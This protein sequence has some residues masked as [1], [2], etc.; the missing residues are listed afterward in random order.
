VPA[1]INGIG[2]HY[3]GAQNRS[4]RVDTCKFCRRSATLSSYD[5]R[6]WFCVIF[7]PLIPM[8]KFRILN[9]CA[10]CRKH[11]RI[12]ADEFA[13]KLAQATAP[14]RQ[15][16][17]TSPRDPQP[18]IELV[19]TLIGW[20]MRSDADRELQSA[21]GVFPQ[22]LGL[23]VLAAQLAVD[24]N[25]FQRAVS[26]Y[27]RACGLDPQNSAA[28]Y[29]YGWVLQH[30]ERYEQAVPLL[31]RSISQDANKRGALYLL[32]KCQM[33][34]S[35]WNDALN[36]FQQLLSVEPAFTKDKQ[37]LRLMRDCK[38]QLGYELTDAE[39]RAGRRLW[40]FGGGTRKR[41]SYE[42]RPNTLVR[43]SLRYAGL[44]ILAIMLLG[45]GFY[46]WD[47]WTNIEVYFD[48]GLDRSVKV[49]LD[50]QKFDV[51]LNSMHTENVSAGA[52]TAIIRGS[53]G[54]EIERLA[55]SVEKLNPFAALMHDRFFVY[56]I[57]TR[58]V[59]RRA[60][61]GYA[62]HAED[63]TYK[64][65]LIGTQRFFEQRDVDFPFMTPP[66]TI[67]LDSTQ[68]IAT[69]VS[70]NIAKEID[71]RKY[72][73]IRMQQGK[74][75]EAK[76][77]IERAVTIAPCDTATRRTEIYL[78]SATGSFETASLTARRW[79]ADCAQDDLEAHRAYQDVNRENGRQE[80][81]RD[82][83]QKLLASSPASGKAHYLFGRVMADPQEAVAQ[84]QEAV[85][86]D[87]KLVWPR[88][89][90]GHAY[91]AMER[92]DAALQEFAAALDMEGCDPSVIVY[93]AN[94]AISKGKP[95]EAVAKVEENRKAHARDLSVLHARWLLA[96]ASADWEGA[97]RM[98]KALKPLETPQTGWWRTAK[99]M[100]MK[101]DP[102][103]DSII[104]K[105]MRTRDFQQIAVDLKIERLIQN[106][107][108]HQSSDLIIK[109]AKE[110]DPTGLAMLEA[111]T[112][113]GLL[114][115]HENNAAQ[116][117]LADAEK[118][119][120]DA[121]TSSARQVMS[122]VVKGLRGTMPLDAVMG[123]ARE[124]D[125]MAHGWF[126]D[127]VL[128]TQAGDRKRASESFGH[129]VRAAADLDFPYLE[130]RAMSQIA[131]R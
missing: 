116:K 44:V 117:L 72:A 122:A 79:I 19:Q 57:G 1:T 109:S 64:S 88:V 22:N 119:L 68:S 42:P 81:L 49:V 76:A 60:S 92:F 73:L 56:N 37:L 13:Q 3:Y 9:D 115:Q 33:K 130:A 111:Y 39:R 7:I 128:A 35:R 63:A 34:L 15:A 67:S 48:N 31:Q 90:L 77:A 18:Y 10:S 100:R 25:D 17:R 99:Q 23:M 12:P 89:A 69:K 74:Q 129:C 120:T 59:Y 65:E 40:P 55:F 41:A 93:Y 61:I 124:N 97:D 71:L 95:D 53:D 108:Y 66:Q 11:Y 83:Y 118:A 4:A 105:G 75:D 50:G 14:L 121:P 85:R 126:V 91:Q 82:E 125:A 94:A 112:A 103:F 28:T 107:D 46:A 21:V 78:A 51:G 16:I 20:E 110:L 27:E 70:F 29:G 6:E 62:Q 106:G 80:A 86:L 54:K 52:H 104:D 8:R 47:R 101:G 43:P 32:G 5:T 131:A 127:A 98:E 114:M 87:P 24:K 30:L 102:A 113:G 84:Y 26:L 2:T 123:V 96:L 45:G 36:S 58:H 38:K